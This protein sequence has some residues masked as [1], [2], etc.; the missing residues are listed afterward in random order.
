[1]KIV[2]I[3]VSN[4]LPLS[5]SIR[6]ASIILVNVLSAVSHYF[7]IDFIGSATTEKELQLDRVQ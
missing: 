3:V 5:I 1:M 7:S 4:L 2:V 6:V